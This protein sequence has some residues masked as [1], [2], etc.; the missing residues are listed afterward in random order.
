MSPTTFKVKLVEADVLVLFHQNGGHLVVHI[1]VL[2]NFDQF[3]LQHVQPCN[4]S[5]R[6][7]F[8]LNSSRFLVKSCDPSFDW[9]LEFS[10]Y[11]CRNSGDVTLRGVLTLPLLPNNQLSEAIALTSRNLLDER[12]VTT[13]TLLLHLLPSLRKA[14]RLPWVRTESRCRS[15]FKLMSWSRSWLWCLWALNWWRWW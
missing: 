11:Y 2:V 3:H 12:F 7:G 5:K 10:R 9:D 4:L 8:G 15:C 14:C 6:K 13:C 1:Q